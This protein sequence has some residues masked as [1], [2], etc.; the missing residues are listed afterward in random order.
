MRRHLAQLS[1]L[2]LTA[3]LLVATGGSAARAAE[4]AA[5]DPGGATASR[6][7]ETPLRR[8]AVLARVVGD[9]SGVP[10]RRLVRVAVTQDLSAKRVRAV[11][12]YAATPTAGT[13]SVVY[14]WLGRLVDGVCQ[15]G[16]LVAGGAGD[17]GAVG[18]FYGANGAA[19]TPIGVSRSQSGAAV[20]LVSA[21]SATIARAA[22]DC[23]DAASVS[24]G[25]PFTPYTVLGTTRL[26]DQY[27]P[28]MQLDAGAPLQ[29]SDRGK[30][31]KV[32][33]A[34]RNHGKGPASGVR[35]VA[36][37]KG[38]KIKKKVIRIGNLADR[39]TASTRTFRVKLRS[40]KA[41]KL[42]VRVQAAGGYSARQRIT[43]A[44]RARPQ[45]LGSITGRYYWGFKTGQ[46]DRGW[47]NV[48][49]WFVNRR[50]VHVGFPGKAGKPTCRKTTKQCRRYTF[51]KRTGQV[52]IGARR[53][54]VTTEGL[55]LGRQW[56][57][58]LTLPRRGSRLNVSLK[59]Q[60]YRGNCG[61][62]CVTWTEWLLLDKRG[63]FVRTRLTI[64]SIGA[65]GVGTVGS[66]VPP[67]Q[68]GRYQVLGNGRI[69]FSYANGTKRVR[70][71]GIE[72]DLR[73]R[74]NPRVAGLV[75]GDVNFY[76]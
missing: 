29:G 3:G 19:T 49:L 46:F 67:D 34:V 71:I 62:S 58:P 64:G 63:R 25:E 39:T 44:H 68:K 33:V 36:S 47:D 18:T 59:N 35:L 20:T 32:S 7:A 57:S 72:H 12:T 22:W 8:T 37:G 70:T 1:V 14:V 4:P 53:G 13:S 76:R 60:D 23:A 40:A 41:R 61:I 43:I 73:G 66:A 69:R 27:A 56:Y 2:T 24:G 11:A 31:A 21:V 9:Q 48:A 17:S 15:R 5:V 16:I 10:Q 65:P 74:P 30:W 38:M 45:R 26:Q 42:T 50:F 54:K 75:V 51:N 52:R 55:Q 28:V 6:A